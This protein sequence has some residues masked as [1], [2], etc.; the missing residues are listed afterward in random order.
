MAGESVKPLLSI[1]VGAATIASAI[2][3]YYRTRGPLSL[4]SFLNK[5]KNLMD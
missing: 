1:S 4:V 2:L 5:S 3:V